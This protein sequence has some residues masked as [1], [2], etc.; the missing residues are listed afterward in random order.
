MFT[1]N[2]KQMLTFKMVTTATKLCLVI[3]EEL[4]HCKNLIVIAQILLQFTSVNQ[5]S[6]TGQI[7]WIYKLYI[8]LCSS[9]K[10]HNIS[11]AHNSFTTNKLYKVRDNLPST[12]LSY[13]ISV[14]KLC[15]VFMCFLLLQT[16]LF[17]PG[18]VLG[19]I[20]FYVFYNVF[21]LVSLNVLCY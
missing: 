11:I 2:L 20:V 10:M 6:L 5:Y 17:T 3:S 4:Q 16:L 15:V 9:Y 1:G 14:F 18:C 12:I 7:K 8:H 19:I 13:A 21:L